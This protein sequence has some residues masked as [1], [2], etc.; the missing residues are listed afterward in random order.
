MSTGRSDQDLVEGSGVG[1]SSSRHSPSPRPRDD[2]PERLVEATLIR[3]ASEGSCSS[4]P[5]PQPQQLFDEASAALTIVVE[6]SPYHEG[7]EGYAGVAGTDQDEKANRSSSKWNTSRRLI[8]FVMVILVAVIVALI[9]GVVVSG[10]QKD[11]DTN[12]NN[13]EAANNQPL[14]LRCS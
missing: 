8:C 4:H 1:G 6:A 11:D 12:N 10:H 5:S 9:I 2:S 14:L 7:E 13:L 3:D